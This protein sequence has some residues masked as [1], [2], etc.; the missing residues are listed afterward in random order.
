MTYL[1]RPYI[2]LILALSITSV[3]AQEWVQIYPNYANYP[4]EEIV[5][6]K[7]DNFGR[8]WAASRFAIAKYVNGKWTQYLGENIGIDFNNI[9]DFEFDDDNN[10]WIAM[11]TGVLKFDGFN[12]RFSAASTTYNLAVDKNNKVWLNSRVKT[13]GWR[14][15]SALYRLNE[16]HDFVE[17]DLRVIGFTDSIVSYVTSDE[18]GNIWIGCQTEIFMY[19]GTNYHDFSLP[20]YFSKNIRVEYI[21]AI[22]TNDI[23]IGIDNNV[24]SLYHYSDGEWNV[25]RGSGMFSVN[26][27][28]KDAD[29]NIWSGGLS[30]GL[31]KYDGEEWTHYRQYNSPFL[32]EPIHSMFI[33]E[34]GIIWMATPQGITTYD[35]KDEWKY[36]E[37][38][39]NINDTRYNYI[40]VDENNVKW[41]GSESTGLLKYTDS[42]EVVYDKMN[43]PLKDNNITYIIK[44]NHSRLLIGTAY[45]GFAAFDGTS[46]ELFTPEK[47]PLID[48]NINSIAV[49]KD[50][51]LWI[52]NGKN[53]VS[54]L[55]GRWE[56]YNS[57]NSD[58]PEDEINTIAIDDSNYVWC[59]TQRSGIVKFDKETLE[60]YNV[61]NSDYY[62]SNKINQLLVVE[63]T[64]WCAAGTR[65]YKLYYNDNYELQ[66]DIIVNRGV[67]S[68]TYDDGIIWGTTTGIIYKLKDGEV[69]DNTLDNDL[70]H[71]SLLPNHIAIDKN[72]N[73]W[74]ADRRSGIYIFNENKVVSVEEENNPQPT[75]F[76]LLQN[77][78]NPFNPTTTISFTIPNRAEVTLTVFDIL[79][80]K[81]ATLLSE[82]VN[83][84]TH[85]VTFNAGDLPSGVYLYH[86]NA[87][88][89]VQAKKMLL[90]K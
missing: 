87:G 28:I 75:E 52:A 79:G 54:Y 2:F 24:N 80:R 47:T 72:K 38:S 43:T 60:K 64:I 59:G 46:W 35:R 57:T 13:N 19:D 71:S 20:D 1:K 70:F 51:K 23:W 18:K 89:Y 73:L 4:N 65:M 85:Q 50:E 90:I 36:Y 67:E 58:M 21:Y 69:S 41:I 81:V 63:D 83:S 32:R 11:S 86:L 77:Y 48:E 9:Y 53:L 10:V 7:K 82:S 8:I 5:V 26:E 56:V 68:I 40:F 55:D 78:P 12:W 76:S 22:D 25:V 84:G 62:L 74:V 37:H 6:I 31:N 42:V 33:D 27:I 88:S 39:T 3:A 29:G 16:N 45:N 44:D 17:L 14:Y 15:R 49:D 66:K 61:S 34:E 30:S